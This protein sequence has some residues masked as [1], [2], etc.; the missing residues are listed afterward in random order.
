MWIQVLIAKENELKHLAA[1]TGPSPGWS[2]PSEDSPARISQDVNLYTA[3]AQAQQVFELCLHSHRQAYLVCIDGQIEVLGVAL[4]T[5]EAVEIQP[6]DE[7]DLPMAITVGG[8]GSHMLIVE[9]AKERPLG[10]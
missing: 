10:I 5:G 6:A 7:M 3:L 1:G 8:G 2:Y 9:M 4:S